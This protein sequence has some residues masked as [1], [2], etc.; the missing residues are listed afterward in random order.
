MGSVCELAELRQPPWRER[1]AGIGLGT[2]M[3]FLVGNSCPVLFYKRMTAVTRGWGAHAHTVSR[4]PDIAARDRDV[5]ASLRPDNAPS[6]ISGLSIC[7]RAAGAEVAGWVG[8][9]EEKR[10]SQNMMGLHH[11][12]PTRANYLLDEC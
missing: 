3:A 8:D 7:L 11:L 9:G 12:S 1:V 5:A 2:S 4:C 6:G 10:A